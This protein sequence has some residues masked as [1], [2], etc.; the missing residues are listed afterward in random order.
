MVLAATVYLPEPGKPK[1]VLYSQ[2]FGGRGI[3]EGSVGM[4]TMMTHSTH[5]VG[6]GQMGVS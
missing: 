3:S 2:L 6:R 4:L 5:Q 1:L